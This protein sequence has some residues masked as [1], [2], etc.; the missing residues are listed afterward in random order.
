MFMETHND[1]AKYH[2]RGPSRRWSRNRANDAATTPGC[3]PAPGN[4][5]GIGAN[6]PA[7]ERDPNKSVNAGLL[8]RSGKSKRDA[9]QI[10]YTDAR[11]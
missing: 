10:R 7:V 8:Y 3:Y 4:R 5:I 9:A 11:W 6:G 2:A 1:E